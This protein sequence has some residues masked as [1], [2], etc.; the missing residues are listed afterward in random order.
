MRK[1]I[2]LSFAVAAPLAA[3][4]PAVHLI[5]APDAQSK[6]V[7]GMVPVVR[8]LPGGKLLVNDV[9]KRQLSMLDQMLGVT[10]IVADSAS[11]GA[12]SYG[13]RA[14]GLIPYI[15]DSS[16]FIDPAGLSMFVIDP[17]GKIARVGSVPRAQDAGSIGNNI[18]NQAALDAKGRLVYRGSMTFAR[19]V[20]GGR[21]GTPG[22]AG[23]PAALGFPEPPDSAA[24]VRVDLASRKL[25]TAAFFKI[26]KVKMNVQQTDRGFTATSEINPMPLLDDWA[27]LADGSIAIVRGQDYHVDFVNA[28]GSISA[29]TKIPYEWQRLSDEDKIA[30]IDSARKT[31]EAARAA[32]ANA[33]AGGNAPI[34][35]GA[36]GG[37]PRMVINMVGGG[38]TDGGG[39]MAQRM[40]AGGAA[41]AAMGTI[42][43]VSP[44]ELPDYRPAFSGGAVRGDADGNVWVRT[45]AVRPG[46]A[47]QIYDVISR[48]GELVDRIQ[49]PA[50]RQIAGFGKGGVVYLTARDASG[51]WIERTH[52]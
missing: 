2:L 28:D 37:A 45:T 33:P 49:L 52:R 7:F 43:F 42:A 35:G 44:S 26:A 1:L 31:M 47:G 39:G 27:V 11:G 9:Q 13:A 5:A 3:Q 34:V 18:V 46:A 6:P 12:N 20:G 29:G 50:G 14:G 17:A 32:M 15:A 38:G 36:D 24:V 16:L 19:G 4:A 23:G 22:A 25:D 40:M 48:R 41:G 30:V 8:Q 21:A 51:A 10:A